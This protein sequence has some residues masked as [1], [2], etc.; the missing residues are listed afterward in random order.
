MALILGL[1]KA[2]L[3][4]KNII[5]KGDSLLVIKQLNVNKR[6]SGKS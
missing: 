3:G 6:S 1:E 2:F 5:V 4:I